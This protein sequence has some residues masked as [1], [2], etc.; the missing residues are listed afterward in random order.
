MSDI[1]VVKKLLKVENVV[2][3]DTIQTTVT[4]DIEFPVKVKKIWDTE[5]E[6][7]DVTAKPIEDKVI[8]EGVIHKQIFFVADEDRT[9]DGVQ[10][11]KGEVFEKTVEEKF[12]AFV[13]VPG[14]T[15]DLNVQVHPRIEFIDYDDLADD[16][17][18]PTDTWRQTVILEIF[19]KVTET[20]QIEV[21]TDVTSPD[22]QLDVIKELLKVQS[23]IGEDEVQAEVDEDLTFPRNVKK[24]KDVTTRIKDVTTK[25]IPDKVIVEGI[26]H[27]Q[28]FYVE[29]DTGRVF[30][31]SVD[32]DFD[33][34][35]EIPGAEEGMNA[36]VHTR[37]ENVDINLKTDTTAKQRTIIEVFVKVTEDLQIEVVTDVVGEGIEVEKDL[38]KVESVVGEN[39]KQT[40]VTNDVSFPVPVKKIVETQTKVEINRRDT[41]PIEDKVIIEGTIHKQVFFVDLCDDSVREESFDETFSAF[42]EVPGTEPG[43]NLQIHP[44]VE[45]VLYEEPDYPANVC[46]I[47][48]FDPDAFPWKQTVILAIFVKVTESVQLDIVTDVIQVGPEPTTTTECP[49]GTTLTFVT[50][51]AGDTLF[52][53]AQRFN[54]T[55]EAIEELNPGIDPLNLQIGQTIKVCSISGA[56]G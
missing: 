30:E 16:P 13:D 52:K 39:E 18:V 40:S 26:L 12:S 10:F 8:I 53:I 5:A 46:E 25:I 32:E 34:F 29:K 22:I 45:D 15:P 31:M 56:K 43:M 44:R 37:V 42:V 54:T 14:T 1:D 47:E 7:E 28:I 41:K 19:V 4:N 17:Y 55:V 35:V 21:V 33:A 50:I 20:V 11:Q 36:Q 38:L 48:P 24:V 9:V 27:K 23:V 2:G 3:E 49:P 51:K 6:L